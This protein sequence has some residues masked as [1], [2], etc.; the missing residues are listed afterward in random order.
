M[1]FARGLQQSCNPILMT[2]AARVGS[3]K[4]YSYFESFGYLDKTGIDL[5]GEARTIFHAK[6]ALGTTEL[7]TASFGQRFKVSPISQLTAICAVANGGF[8]W[9]HRTCLTVL[10]TMTA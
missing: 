9:S 7:A 1:T 5:P 8:T 10:W 4:F 6:G 2:I 3:E